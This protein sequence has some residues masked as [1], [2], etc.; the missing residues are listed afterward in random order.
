M[1]GNPR[2]PTIE[3]SAGR[4]RLIAADFQKMEGCNHNRIEIWIDKNGCPH[5]VN[6]VGNPPHQEYLR[7][8]IDELIPIN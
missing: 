4:A 5:T 7:Q 3:L 8:D 6:L 1:T 2:P